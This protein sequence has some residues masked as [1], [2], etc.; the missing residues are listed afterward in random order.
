NWLG[1]RDKVM[2]KYGERWF[3][4]WAFFLAYSTIVSRQGGA[5]VFQIT[6]HKNL[7]AFHRVEGVRKHAGVHMRMEGVQK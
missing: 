2:A 3:R 1:N 5:S 7:N 6:C 4:I